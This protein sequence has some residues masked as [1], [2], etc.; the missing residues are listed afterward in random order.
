VVVDYQSA[1]S[2][3]IQRQRNGVSVYLTRCALTCARDGSHVV[4]PEKHAP[5]CGVALRR[6]HR[7]LLGLV[8]S[9]RV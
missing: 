8:G 5:E 9:H 1:R 3:R 7:A 6:R 2:A 4:S